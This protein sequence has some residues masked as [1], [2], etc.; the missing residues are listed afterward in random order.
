[1]YEIRR[2]VWTQAARSRDQQQRLY[3]L[4][5]PHGQGWFLPIFAMAV[6]LKRIPGKAP[7]RG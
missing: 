1:M 3:F 4:P 6:L 7:R 2:V 5:L